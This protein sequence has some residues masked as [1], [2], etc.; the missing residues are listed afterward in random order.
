MTN[1]RTRKGWKKTTAVE[2]TNEELTHNVGCTESH[3]LGGPI[4]TLS[5][6][7]FLLFIRFHV[8]VVFVF[9]EHDRAQSPCGL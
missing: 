2:G 1:N 8:V 6:N 4:F 7:I 9:L 5:L 3:G